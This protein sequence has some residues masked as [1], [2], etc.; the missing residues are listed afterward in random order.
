MAL[1][2]TSQKMHSSLCAASE[3]EMLVYVLAIERLDS[4]CSDSLQR[5]H[6]SS[7]PWGS[8]ASQ[9]PLSEVSSLRMDLPWIVMG[10]TKPSGS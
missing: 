4:A 5:T 10:A 8:G 7:I 6:D 2:N 3:G 9:S 1:V